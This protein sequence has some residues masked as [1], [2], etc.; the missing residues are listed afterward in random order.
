MGDQGNR[1]TAPAF[2]TLRRGK[3]VFAMA[4]ARQ[5]RGVCDS[6]DQRRR[7]TAREDARPT[8]GK[9]LQPPSGGWRGGSVS[10]VNRQS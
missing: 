2:A 6:S 7:A 8:N 3:P 1:A 9:C 10:I 5:A 4:T